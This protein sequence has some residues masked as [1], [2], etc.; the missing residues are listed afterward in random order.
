MF[1]SMGKDLLSNSKK[2][3]SHQEGPTSFSLEHCSLLGICLIGVQSLPEK[4]RTL[5]TVKAKGRHFLPRLA[6]GDPW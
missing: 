2:V 5:E 3:C 6:I 1:V 4:F